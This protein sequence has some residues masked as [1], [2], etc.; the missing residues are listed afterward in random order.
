VVIRIEGQL[1]LMKHRRLTGC[2]IVAVNARRCGKRREV[3]KGFGI[4]RAAVKTAHAADTGQFQHADELT[5]KT[6]D[7]HVS[8]SI[9]KITSD[10]V[11]PGD[12]DSLECL[13]ALGNHHA[14][15]LAL[16]FARI[17]RNDPPSWR[18]SIRLKPKH[19]AVVS[20]EVISSIEIRA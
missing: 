14:P 9:A 5:P 4:A 10:E 17:D 15:T 11:M 20:D 7:F 6:Q 13:P 18:V 19:G 2:D 12:A 3:E 8:L 16:R 1:W